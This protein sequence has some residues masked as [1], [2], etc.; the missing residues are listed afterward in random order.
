[1]HVF[2]NYD[3]RTWIQLGEITYKYVTFDLRESPDLERKIYE[4]VS[5]SKEYLRH[6]GQAEKFAKVSL[7]L[8]VMPL[9]LL[10]GGI[11]MVI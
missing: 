9:G 4:I 8:P 10:F 5:S 1:M 3:L 11:L 2:Q 6:V 7:F